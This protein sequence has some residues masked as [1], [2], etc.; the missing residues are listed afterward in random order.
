MEA[1]D[2]EFDDEV[3]ALLL[4]SSLPE[5]WS[6]TV[7]IVSASVG[8]AKI[9]L[10][11][12]RDLIVSEE[13]RRKESCSTSGSAALSTGYKGRSDSRSKSNRG[14][15]QSRGEGKPKD[16]SKIKCWNCGEMGHY[17][18]NCRHPLKDKSANA[19]TD[20]IADTLILSVSSPLETWVLDSGASFHS[21]SSD[22]VMK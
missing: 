21:C 3:Q 18:S 1:V 7:T 17:K 9:K 20:E 16:K 2:I 13:V 22:D 19:A 15:S 6:G 10:D 12:V 8:K 4:L 14:R 5:S 11:E